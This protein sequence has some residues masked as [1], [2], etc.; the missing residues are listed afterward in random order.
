MPSATGAPELNQRR[1]LPVFVRESWPITL[2]IA[3]LACLLIGFGVDPFANLDR[4]WGDKLLRWRFDAGME[5]KPDARIFLVG[6]Q[7]NDLV[8]AGTTEAEY[9]IY[10][11]ILNT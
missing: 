8:A 1:R 2:S 11:D 4:Q 6:I 3:I 7:T 5:T 10:A 9:K